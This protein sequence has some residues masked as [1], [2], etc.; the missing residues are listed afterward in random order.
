VRP[1][2]RLSLRSFNTDIASRQT[3]YKETLMHPV[4]NL[5]IRQYLRIVCAAL[6]PVVVTA[7]LSIPLALGGHPGEPRSAQAGMSH[8][9]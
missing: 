1:Q 8:M 6:V 3:T 4:L 5:F 9:T 2:T 7:F